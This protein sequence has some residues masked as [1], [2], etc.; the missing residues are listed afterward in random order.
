MFESVTWSGKAK[1]AFLDW[2]T[3]E[4][5]LSL[6]AR[7][8]LERQWRDW[9][10][11]Y[12]A[13]A[14]QP[15]KRFPF[16]GANNYVMPATA[17]DVDQLY[18]NELITLHATDDLWS[19][20]P[21]NERWVKAAK[22]LQDFL[23][24]TDRN[25]LKMFDVD[26]RVLLEKFK[27]GTGIYKTQ[28]LFEER[29]VKTYGPTG[30][31][32]NATKTSS[33]PIVEHVRLNDFI[34][35]PSA[36]HHQPDM[37]GGA[38]WVA[39]R[40]RI[41]TNRLKWIASSQEPLFPNFDKAAM[42]QVIYFEEK[43]QTQYAAKVYDLDYNKTPGAR[44]DAFDR[45]VVAG[46]T[47]HSS[48]GSPLT[49]EIELFE[50]HAR[51]V[52]GGSGESED[53]VILLYHQPTRLIVRA[54]YQPYLFSLNGVRPYD[55]TR[56]FPSDGFYGIGVCEQ[57]EIFQRLESDLT[58]FMLDNVLLTNSRMI[59]A[60][61]GSNIMPGE[62][63]YPWK[64]FV[65]DGD[66][67]EA[68]GQFP[69]ADIYQSLP[70]AIGMVK[71]AGK[72]RTG[73]GDIQLGNATEL[74]GR[75]PATTAMAMLQ[76]GKKRPDLSIKMAR[77]EGLSIVGLRVLQLLQQFTTTMEEADGQRWLSVM[78]GV[79]GSPEGEELVK[80]I[81]M[82]A[83]NAEFGVVVQLTATSASANKEAD[84]QSKLALL[85]LAGQIA[86]QVVQLAMT[87]TQMQGTPVGQTA[88][89]SAAGIVEL[90]K[91]VLETYDIRD[92]ENIVPSAEGDGATQVPAGMLGGGDSGA[93]GID[94]A[95]IMAALSGAAGQAGLGGSQQMSPAAGI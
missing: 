79:L 77:Y 66:P 59:V 56:M 90:F 51:V 2:I 24:W 63:I 70:M 10:T 20:S 36:W 50:I 21:M 93:G 78:Q 11:Q 84:R 74:P 40:M 41:P 12:R 22:P 3:Y 57:K 16:E 60:R 26:A 17:V 69:M 76:E 34:I 46:A 42:K 55:V 35:P 14:N 54:I 62:P 48:I 8:S 5:N 9:I 27:L 85:Q 13:P 44:G 45:S 32:V 30:K 67:R 6:G 7:Q 19:V 28:W 89:A 81:T 73:V 75:M 52:T 91:R 71:E 58:N 1:A 33:R 25:T 86:P 18:S 4:L 37:Q 29:P 94:P 83:E 92:P 87:G 82:P 68:F 72:V 53:D 47:D 39:E 64:I 23:S 31:I 88:M 43:N 38:R 15:Q 95:S 49:N 65:T 80:N 61:A